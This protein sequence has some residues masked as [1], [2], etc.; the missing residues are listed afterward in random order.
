MKLVR[1][2]IPDIIKEDGKT[3][4]SRGCVDLQEFK[5]RLRDKMIEETDEFLEEPSYEEAADMYEVLRAFANLYNLDMK[6][7]HSTA[8]AKRTERG[9]FDDGIV[10]VKVG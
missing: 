4:V 7:I 3:C 1:D 6:M 2:Y 10:L 8:D 5:D 9:G